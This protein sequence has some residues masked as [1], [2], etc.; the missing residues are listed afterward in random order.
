[1]SEDKNA[2]EW[3]PLPEFPGYSISNYGRVYNDDTGMEIRPTINQRGLAMIGPSKD[4]KQYR[5]GLAPLVAD[6]FLSRAGLADRF[7]TP[8]HLDGDRSNCEVF[9]LM[10]R[11]RWFAVMY[12][13]QFKDPKSSVAVPIRDVETNEWYPNSWDA[14]IKHGLL[15]IHIRNS[16]YNRT[17]TFPTHQTFELDM[18]AYNED[19]NSTDI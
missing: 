18:E 10:W 13:K 1:M 17:W 11:P 16:I 14:A 7:D 9:N 2:E 3:K 5:R 6:V 19:Y 4:G 8:I 15:D 12:H